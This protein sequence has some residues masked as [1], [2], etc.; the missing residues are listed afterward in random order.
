LT[1]EFDNYGFKGQRQFLALFNYLPTNLFELEETLTK[2]LVILGKLKNLQVCMGGFEVGKSS[3]Q[4]VGQLDLHGK[5]SI[6]NLENIVD[7]R[8]A[9]PVDLYNKIHL[10]GLNLSWDFEVDNEVS[11]KTGEVLVKLQPAH[12]N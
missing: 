5:L 12:V 10:V 1:R 11:I 8:D 6:T 3:V 4:Q 9:L 7:P 2:A